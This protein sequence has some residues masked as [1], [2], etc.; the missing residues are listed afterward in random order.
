MKNSVHQLSLESRHR[1]SILTLCFENSCIFKMAVM[2]SKRAQTRPFQKYWVSKESNQ[3]IKLVS[4][5][6]LSDTFFGDT[7]AIQS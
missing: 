4:N 5:G 3:L 7:K 2:D 6:C 1:D